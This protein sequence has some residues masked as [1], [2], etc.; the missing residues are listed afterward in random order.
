MRLYQHSCFRPVARETKVSLPAR[1]YIQ[2]DCLMEQTE[3]AEHPNRTVLL[4][5]R[6][7]LCLSS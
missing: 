6:R 7:F 3:N 2:K 4:K 5:E 1:F